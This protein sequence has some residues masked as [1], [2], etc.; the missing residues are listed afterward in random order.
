MSLSSFK[1]E[2]PKEFLDSEVLSSRTSTRCCNAEFASRCRNVKLVGGD[3]MN[4]WIG[5]KRKELAETLKGIDVLLI[6]DGEAKLLAAELQPA[7][8]SA[9]DTGR[10]G[11]RPSRSSMASTAPPLF[12]KDGAFGLGG[13]HPFRAPALPD[14]RGLRSNRCRAIRLRADSWDSLPRSRS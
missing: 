2:I 14:R 8:G 1:P 13:G 5:G 6:N 10:W 3:T 7:A 4:F 12:F 9:Q 11:R